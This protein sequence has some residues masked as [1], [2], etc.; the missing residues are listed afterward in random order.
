MDRKT[1]GK[2]RKEKEGQFDRRKKT[3]PVSWGLSPRREKRRKG[4]V[5]RKKRH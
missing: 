1:R 5:S 3:C 4:R 2:K